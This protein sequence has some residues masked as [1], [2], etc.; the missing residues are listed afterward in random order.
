MSVQIYN[1]LASLETA[2]LRDG[3]LLQR[4]EGRY[5]IDNAR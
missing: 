5:V 2:N 4:S 1:F 3:L